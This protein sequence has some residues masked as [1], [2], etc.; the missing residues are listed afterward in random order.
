ML[1]GIGFLLGFQ[2]TPW[3][4]APTRSAPRRRARDYDGGDH[5]APLLPVAS[6][7]KHKL[8]KGCLYLKRL[9]DVDVA[10]LEALVAHSVAE[11]RRRYP[12]VD[13]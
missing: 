8:G 12:S 11:M 1:R 4:N 6:L 10:V 7:G 2:V 5:G 3:W 13:A 9:A